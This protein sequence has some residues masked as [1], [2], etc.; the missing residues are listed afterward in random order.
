MKQEKPLASLADY[1]DDG[2]Y[3]VLFNNQ[4]LLL[5]MNKGKP[6]LLE[7]KCGHFGVPLANGR[8]SG[9]EIVCAE[10]GISFDLTTGA[11]VNRP[12]ENCDPVKVLGFKQ[13][14]GQIFLKKTG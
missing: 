11:I 6:H 5:V 9:N 2:I 3:E 4:S 14:N 12:Y 1:P 7:N 8:L 10:H 13:I